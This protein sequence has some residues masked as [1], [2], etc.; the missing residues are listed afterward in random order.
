MGPQ[1]SLVIQGR[2]GPQHTK[3]LFRVYPGYTRVYPEYTRIYQGIPWIYTLYQIVVQGIPFYR[4][5]PQPRTKGMRI[6]IMILTENLGY[7]NKKVLKIRP[8]F[9][10]SIQ[11]K[12]VEEALLNLRKWIHPKCFYSG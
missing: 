3:L 10:D 7:G 11:W 12:V 2:I 5:G 1:H 6:R 4:I 9:P 8:Y